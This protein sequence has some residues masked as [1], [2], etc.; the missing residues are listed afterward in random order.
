MKKTLKFEF[1]TSNKDDFEK[2]QA[3]EIMASVLDNQTNLK[4]F[5][6]C[7]QGIRKGMNISITAPE[8][9]QVAPRPVGPKPIT[10]EENSKNLKEIHGAVL[11]EPKEE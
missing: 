11:P 4:A 6:Q 10:N 3:V 9:P 7:A 8:Q 5:L 2:M 1:D